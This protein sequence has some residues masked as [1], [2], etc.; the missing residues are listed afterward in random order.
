[1]KKQIILLIIF[2]TFF[3]GKANANTAIEWTLNDVIFNDGGTATGSFTTY[4]DNS[5]GPKH[6]EF[7]NIY[8]VDI[9]T[10]SGSAI[11]ES[12]TFEQVVGVSHS[13]N[14]FFVAPTTQLSS[15]EIPDYS[16][17]LKLT[18][19]PSYRDQSA[20]LVTDTFYTDDFLLSGLASGQSTDDDRANDFIT[21]NPF[22]RIIVSGS[23][24]GTITPVPEPAVA[25]LWFFGSAAL[26]ISAFKRR[27]G[28]P[29]NQTLLAPPPSR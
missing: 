13:G 4:F 6:L 26:G 12:H 11:A 15:I 27:R 21:D 5:Y 19:N 2:A 24:T 8:L 29:P 20:I 17:W 22:E 23:V 7:E 14:S 28:Y 18:F 16:N 10:T 25:W 1:M 3:A 9:Q